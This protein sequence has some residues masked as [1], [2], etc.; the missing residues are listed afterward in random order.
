MKLYIPQ[1]CFI[2]FECKQCT[3]VGKAC[4][5]IIGENELFGRY[6]GDEFVVV[7]KGVTLEHGKKKAA[8][9]EESIRSLQVQEGGHR[10]RL[11]PVLG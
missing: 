5:N 8:R 7:L 4:S 2:S 6:G 9:L 10:F 1:K 11:K 3:E